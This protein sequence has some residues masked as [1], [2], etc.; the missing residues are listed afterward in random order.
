ML[1]LKIPSLG[2]ELKISPTVL[3]SDLEGLLA[4][5]STLR[6]MEVGTK[7]NRLSPSVH[8]FY[9]TWPSFTRVASLAH[10]NFLGGLRTKGK[11]RWG[12]TSRRQLTK[13]VTCI[14]VVGWKGLLLVRKKHEVSNTCFLCKED[15]LRLVSGTLFKSF[16]LCFHSSLKGQLHMVVSAACFVGKMFCFPVFPLKVVYFFTMDLFS[17]HASWETCFIHSSLSWNN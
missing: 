11:K 3:P 8:V 14:I 17:L 10:S 2:I 13:G 7:S 9:S 5:I 12:E 4:L 15:N 1:F 6:F 16:S